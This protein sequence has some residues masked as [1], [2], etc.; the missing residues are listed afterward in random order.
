MELH[1]SKSYFYHNRFFRQIHSSLNDAMAARIAL[2]FAWIRWIL[3]YVTVLKHTARLQRVQSALAR[4]VVNQRSR[5]PFSFPAVFKQLHWLPLERR[6]AVKTLKASHTGRYL[7]SIVTGH[8]LYRFW[9][10]SRYWLKIAIFSVPFLHNNSLVKNDANIFALF[11]HN[12]PHWALRWYK[13]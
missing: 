13:Y 11:F 8:I 1:T 7:S 12:Q 2:A 5:P 9:D 6:T 10:K 3:S 4:V